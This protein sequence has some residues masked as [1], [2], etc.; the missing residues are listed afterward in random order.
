VTATVWA[1]ILVALGT[2][3]VVVRMRRSAWALAPMAIGLIAI[4]ILLATPRIG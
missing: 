2:L 4:L 3:L 1:V